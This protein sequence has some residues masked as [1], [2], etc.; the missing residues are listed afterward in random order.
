MMMM[1]VMVV[2]MTVMMMMVM[3]MMVVMPPFEMQTSDWLS[4]NGSFIIVSSVFRK[5]FW[6][7]DSIGE[8]MSHILYILHSIIFYTVLNYSIF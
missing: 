3:M 6:T 8:P 1:M 2:M 4:Q 5:R 7:M